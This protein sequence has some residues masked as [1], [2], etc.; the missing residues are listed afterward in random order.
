M[1]TNYK[2]QCESKVKKWIEDTIDE[3]QFKYLG[4][5]KF[6]NLALQD[7]QEFIVECKVEMSHALN[8]EYDESKVTGS[9]D[10]QGEAVSSQEEYQKP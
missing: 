6:E 10:K 4:K 5:D 2:S 3:Q 8:A 7:Y 1:L 9:T